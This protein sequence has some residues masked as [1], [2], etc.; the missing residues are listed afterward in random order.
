MLIRPP[1]VR[2]MRRNLWVKMT[3]SPEDYATRDVPSEEAGPSDADRR[4]A[5]LKELGELQ[6]AGVLTEDEF[7]REKARILG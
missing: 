2:D 1:V 4:L 5:A 3:A 7:L 6:A